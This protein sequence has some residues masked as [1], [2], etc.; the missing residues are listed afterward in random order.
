MQEVIIKDGRDTSRVIGSVTVEQGSTFRISQITINSDAQEYM[1]KKKIVA[2]YT[3]A[4]TDGKFDATKMWNQANQV[5]STSPSVLYADIQ[6]TTATEDFF[7]EHGWLFIVFAILTILGLIAIFYF[8]F[9][10]PQVYI[11]V[12][13][14]AVLTILLFVYKDFGGIWDAITGLFTKN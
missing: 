4:A 3:T 8:G 1:V 12:A 13:I 9:Q 11:A 14:V 7:A 6:D 2:L 5:F 10:T